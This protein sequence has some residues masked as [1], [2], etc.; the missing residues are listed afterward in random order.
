MCV[1]LFRACSYL[2]VRDGMHKMQILRVCF[3]AKVINAYFVWVF[4]C[5]D[6]MSKKG[7]LCFLFYV[8]S[9]IFNLRVL[10]FIC[11]SSNSFFISVVRENCHSR[12]AWTIYW[13]SFCLSYH[14]ADLLFMTA[15][16]LR[17]VL[18]NQFYSNSYTLNLFVVGTFQLESVLLQN[19]RCCIW[20]KFLWKS[21]II[22]N[23]WL[24]LKHSSSSST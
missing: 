14:G 17:N 10:S 11:H 20:N 18:R 23:R 22:D 7:N 12:I 2:C 3:F 9:F 13:A 16:K 6:A 8:D 5:Y 21:W 1:Y 4:F 24:S 19:D 15:H